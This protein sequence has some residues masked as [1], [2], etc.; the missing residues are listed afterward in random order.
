MKTAIDAIERLLDG[1]WIGD[2]S[3]DELNV[4]RKVFAVPAREIIEYAHCVTSVEQL[5]HQMRTHEAGTASH[6]KANH[7]KSFKQLRKQ[8]S[9][10]VYGNRT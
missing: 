4:R 8:R 1:D 2:I 9:A 7:P 6:E 5:V 10:V 3:V